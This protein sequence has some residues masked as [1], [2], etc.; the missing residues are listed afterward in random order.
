MALYLARQLGAKVT[1]VT[2]SDEQHALSESRARDAGLTRGGK[3][4]L[5]DYRNT[6]GPFDP[7]RL[8]RHVR[9][10]RPAELPHLLQEERF[11]AETRRRDAAAHDRPHGSSPPPTTRSS[12]KYIF[13]GGYIPALSEVMQ[14]VEK[15]WACGNGC[16]NPQA[17]LCRDA[18]SLATALHGKAGQAKA[19]Y[20]PK[21]CRILGILSRGVRKRLPLAEPRR[22]PAP[23]R[24]S[25][26]GRTADTRLYRPRRGLPEGP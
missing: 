11:A 6:E 17:P 9:A 18:T 25:P 20:D 13:P 16:G 1:G 24:P 26:G 2:L 12:E 23:A 14:A 4:L 3:F 19:L 7:H 22:L 5:Q 8:R 15:K 10:C 21:F